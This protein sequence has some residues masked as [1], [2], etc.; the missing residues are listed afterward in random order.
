MRGSRAPVTSR[1][2]HTGGAR[3][4]VP[5]G[6]ARAKLLERVQVSPE[7]LLCGGCIEALAR[8]LRVQGPAPLLQPRRLAGLGLDPGLRPLHRRFQARALALAAISLRC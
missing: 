4:R 3:D 7:L 6:H 1:R 8:I 2:A 5:H